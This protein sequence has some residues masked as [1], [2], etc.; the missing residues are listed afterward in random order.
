[1]NLD[2]FKQ[3]WQQRQRDLDG[4]VDHVIKKARSRM[5]GFDRTIWWRDMRET[6]V[7]VLMIIW[8][9]YDLFRPQN[10]LSKCGTGLLIASCLW[11]IAVLHWARVKGKVAR[12][13]LPVEDYCKAELERVD[14][15]IWLLRNIHWWYLGPPFVAFAVIIAAEKPDASGLIMLLTFIVPLYGFLY[16]LNQVAVKN[17]LLPLRREL[18]PSNDVD[19]NDD[20][21][22]T[23]E[24]ITPL[25]PLKVERSKIFIAVIGLLAITF[26]GAFLSAFIDVD[27]RAPKV[28]PFT[29]VRFEGQQIIVTFEKRNY[30]WLELDGIKVAAIVATAKN[31]FGELWKKRISEDLVAVLWAM[32]HQPADTVSLLLRDLETNQQRLVERAPMTTDNRSAVHQNRINE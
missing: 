15:Q 4:R 25:E 31:R 23:H 2:D 11:I 5:A 26:V 27:D 8:F 30:Q 6:F 19:Q 16:W 32:N 22:A 13:D 9:S 20:A 28:S 21:T 3:P 24:T 18:E 12:A 10:L 14:R 17:Q 7:A 29:D 1:M